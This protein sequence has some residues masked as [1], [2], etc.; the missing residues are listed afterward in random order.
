[1]KKSLLW[2]L[3]IFLTVYGSMQ[4]FI[5]WEIQRAFP[6]LGEWRPW[7]ALV[8]FLMGVSPILARLLE[9]GHWIE[10][11]RGVAWVGYIWMAI[12]LWFLSI[13][14]AGELW[15]LGVRLIDDMIGVGP[16][17]LLLPR[18]LL[19]GTGVLIIVLIVWG[20]YEA[21]AL[22]LETLTVRTPRFIPGT[23][24]IRIVQISDVHFSLMTRRTW[25]N[26]LLARIRE[27][28]P[29]L[30]VSTGDLC[31]SS[32]PYM[33]PI[34]E[35]LAEQPAP[36]GKLAVLGNH[37]YLHGLDG[38]IRFHE[39]AGFRLLRAE[40][41]SVGNRLVV[42]GVDD[43]IGARLDLPTRLDEDRAL[44]PVDRQA[45]VLFLKHQPRIDPIALD[46]FDL[47]LSGHTHRGQIV[48]FM[49]FVR[50]LY[51]YLD[52]CYPLSNGATLYVSR[53]TGTWGPPL[54]VLSSP[55]VTLI[56]IEPEA[57]SEE[58]SLP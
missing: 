42:A 22:R 26:K 13:G 5:F 57:V 48:P 37:E 29:D 45:F 10:L 55:E 6:D 19:V 11:A 16:T 23:R 2:F 47:Q 38:A 20:W 49:F 8:L 44:P 40:R 12:S 28:E 36:L 21:S 4:Y 51:P 46:R 14:V 50:L 1:M 32:G 43:P 41:I 52:G 58:P 15:N 53:G 56:I 27:A 3:L 18:P 39:A 9:N 54:R 34:M 31:D 35:R 25:V 7:L 30:L 33:N 17:L 24:P